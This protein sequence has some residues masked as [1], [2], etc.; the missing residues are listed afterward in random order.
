MEKKKLKKF[1]NLG[2]LNF[3]D[4][5]EK[6]NRIFRSLNFKDKKKNYILKTK[7][8]INNETFFVKNLNKEKNISSLKFK[9]GQII[10]V[11]KSSLVIKV[12][13]SIIKVDLTKN[14]KK[15]KNMKLT[16]VKKINFNEISKIRK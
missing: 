14:V 15:T 5:Y 8:L 4:T 12:K 16:P 9:A 2:F 1:P 6:N 7:I 11:R 10:E 13:D 3:D